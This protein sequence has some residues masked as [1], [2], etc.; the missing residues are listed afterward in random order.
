MKDGAR[1]LVTAQDLPL[2]VT[3]S[4]GRGRV[5]ALMFSPEREPF[6]S[7]KN[8]PTFWA[9][10]TEV[11]GEWYLSSDFNQPMRP[12]SDGIFGSMIETGQVHKLPIEWL[13]LLLIVYLVVIGPFDQFWLRRI[14]RPMLTWITFPC[15]VVLFSLLIYFI[16]YK[17]RAGES[18]WNELH[19]VDV[20]SHGDRAELR[21][22]TYASVYSPSNQRYLLESPQKYATLR[23]EF[24]G[25]WGGGQSSEKANVSQ[26]GDS[27][28]AEIFVPVWTS[29]LFVSDWWQSA[30]VPL[31]ATVIPKGDG[32]QVKI[33]NHTERKLT[34]AQIVLAGYVMPLGSLAPNETRTVTVSMAQGTPLKDFVS[35]HGQHFHGAISSRQQ[36]FGATERVTDPPNGSIAASFISQMGGSDENYTGRFISPPGLDLSSVV[37]RGG[38]VVLAWA[39]DYSPVKPMYQFSPR[40][41]HKDTLWRIAVEDKSKV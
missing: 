7:W 3:A 1:V 24:V 9:K 28:K 40:R 17:L 34:N 35:T 14:G 33:E 15:Y 18:E 30:E 5:T 20:L 11:P 29:Q 37:E 31:S 26:N 23:G 22:R 6:R 27:F 4:V 38:A 39:A 36:A 12:S 10:L 21:G 19:L 32:W 25:M 16:G 13:L 8:L 2:M 41:S